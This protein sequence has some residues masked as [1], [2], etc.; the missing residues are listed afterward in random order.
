MNKE[1][2]I[3]TDDNKVINQKCIRWVKKM[4]ECMEVCIKKDGCIAQVSTHSVCK[5]N[6]LE[7]Y[8]KLQELFDT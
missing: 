6:S 8:N 5:S 3:K 4:N 7:S 1:D 2:F